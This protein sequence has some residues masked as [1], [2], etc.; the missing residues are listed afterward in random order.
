MKYLLVSCVLCGAF[1]TGCGSITGRTHLAEGNTYYPGV[2]TDIEGAQGDSEHDY[3]F[4]QGTLWVLDLPF[5]AIGDTLMLPMDYF[6]G[7]WRY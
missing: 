1:L 5:S 4:I 7:P 2:Q 6:H 3:N